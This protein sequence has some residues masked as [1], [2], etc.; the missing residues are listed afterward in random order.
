MLALL[1]LEF[2]GKGFFEGLRIA[3][4][5]GTSLLF[6]TRRSASRAYEARNQATSLG[7]ARA[8]A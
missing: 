2:D 1:A 8:A 4:R 3:E 6:S 7:A 5:A